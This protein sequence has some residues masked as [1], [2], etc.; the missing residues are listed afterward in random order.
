MATI[1]SEAALKNAI[2]QLEQ[3]QAAEGKNL[4][5]ELNEVYESLKPINLLKNTLREAAQSEEVHANLLN[6][7]VGI[8]TG[9]MANKM[10]QSVSNSRLKSLFGTLLQVG[11]TKLVAQNPEFIRTIGVGALK[12]IK[13]K[14]SESAHKRKIEANNTRYS[15]EFDY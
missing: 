5:V 11:V 6:T 2:S 14:L 9:L 8:L 1:N 10:F 13:V 12:I 7:G 3:Q 15:D 4:R